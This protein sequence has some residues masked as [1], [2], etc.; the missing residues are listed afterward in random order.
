MK[1]EDINEWGIGR[2]RVEYLS[3]IAANKLLLKRVK[4]LED[5]IKERNKNG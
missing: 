3:A 4:Q 2:F 5:F 1:K